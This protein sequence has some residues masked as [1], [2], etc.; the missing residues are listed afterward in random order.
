[1]PD[2]DLVRAHADEALRFALTHNYSNRIVR[3][4]L[5]ATHAEGGNRVHQIVCP[6]HGTPAA[7]LLVVDD[8]A[9]AREWNRRDDD[10]LAYV[11]E[12]QRFEQHINEHWRRGAR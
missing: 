3:S 11:L 4:L 9:T 8:S 7:S 12:K 1:M 10:Y 6:V 5:A 2:D